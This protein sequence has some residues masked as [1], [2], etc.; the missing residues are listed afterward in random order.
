MATFCGIK[1]VLL[2]KWLWNIGLWQSG[3]HLS[4]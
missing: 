2:L 1:L 3:T 4:V